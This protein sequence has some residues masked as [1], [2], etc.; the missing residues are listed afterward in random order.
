MALCKVM[1]VGAWIERREVGVRA[2]RIRSEKLREDRYKKDLLG[3]LR[4]EE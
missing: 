1:L 3:F 2:R 4:G